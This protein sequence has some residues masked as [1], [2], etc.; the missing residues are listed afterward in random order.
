[1]SN[2]IRK[3]NKGKQDAASNTKLTGKPSPAE[4]KNGDIQIRMGD[5]GPRLYAKLGN[6]WLSSVLTEE[7]PQREVKTHW[8]RGKMSSSI[9]DNIPLPSWIPAAAVVG[10]MFFA[11]HSSNLWHIYEWRSNTGTQAAV[12]HRVFYDRGQHRIEVDGQGSQFAQSKW[13]H[14]IVFYI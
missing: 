13:Y 10:V 11:N 14:V 5:Q 8:F 6:K 2:K 7:S 4:G 9:T 12:K 3:L 1:M